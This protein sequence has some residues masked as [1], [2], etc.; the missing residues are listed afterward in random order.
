MAGRRNWGTGT[1]GVSLLLIAGCLFPQRAMQERSAGTWVGTEE[2]GEAKV[3]T[4]KEQVPPPPSPP[5]DYHP[6]APLPAPAFAEYMPARESAQVELRPAVHHKSS[7]ENGSGR[8]YEQ[9]A[10][11]PVAVRA[12][13][14]ALARHPEE[15]NKLLQEKQVPDRELVLALLRLTAEITEKDAEK[16]TAEEIAQTQELLRSVSAKLRSRAALKLDKVSFCKRIEGF[17]RFEPHAS[18]YEF[19]AGYDGK[20]GERVQVYAEIRNFAS[21][22]VQGRY[23]TVLETSLAIHDAERREVVRF[24][25]GRCVDRSQTPRQD[26]FLNFQL[27]IPAKLKPGLYTLWVH[28]KDVTGEPVREVS[29]SL[30]FKVRAP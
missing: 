29:T 18:G 6:H 17:G 5:S 1:A 11:E 4:V 9:T 2:I 24:D 22:A 10:K 13:R 16:L 15:A 12:L 19:Q 28:V 14:Q 26:Y 3:E 21:R 25:L 23:E 7:G 20:P 8:T 27:H 30:D